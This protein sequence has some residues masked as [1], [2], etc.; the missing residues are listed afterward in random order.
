MSKRSISR[1]PTSTVGHDMMHAVFLESELRAIESKHG[2]RR[3]R[4]IIEDIRAELY[5]EKSGAELEL[6]DMVSPMREEQDR[7]DGQV[8]FYQAVEAL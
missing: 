5:E 8:E 4:G 7:T 3:I 1:G 6:V 2:Q